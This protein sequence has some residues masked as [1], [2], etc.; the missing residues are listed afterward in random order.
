MRIALAGLVGISLAV[1]AS[2]AV[3]QWP[4]TPTSALAIG[5]GTGQ[6]AN[7]RLVAAA[8]GSCYVSWFDSRST[9]FQPMLQRLS[10]SGVEQWA[11]NGISFA[12]NTNTGLYEPYP[13]LAVDAAGNA[14][15][16]FT[17]TS[18][19]VINAHVTVNK[20]SPAGVKLWGET[21]ISVP[22]SSSSTPGAKLAVL[23]NGDVVV[24]CA[25]SSV[26][27]LTRFNSSGVQLGT[28]I[29]ISE[30][31]HSML[32]SD[33]CDGGNGSVIAL[34]QRNAGTSF[35]SLHSLYMQKFDTAGNAMWPV[36]PGATAVV[37]YG[38]TG[39]IAGG[40][41]PTL[42]PDGNGGAVCGWYELTGPAGSGAFSNALVQH[43]RSNGVFRF[44]ANG[45]PVSPRPNATS[46]A[47]MSVGCT[48]DYLP[49]TDEI[50]ATWVETLAAQQLANYAV[51]AQKI[52]VTDG[53]DGSEK[54]ASGG[55]VLRAVD[56][57]TQP[58]IITTRASQ[59]GCYSLWLT[60]LNAANGTIEAQR[61]DASGTKLWNSGDPLVFGPTPGYYG[62]RLGAACLA[63]G[64]LAVSFSQSPSLS[65][66]GS[67]LFVTRLKA[68]GTFGITPCNAADVAGFGGSQGPDGQVTVDDIVFYLSNFFSG[69]LAVADVA[70]FGGGATPDGQI[71]VDDLVYFLSQFF[72]PCN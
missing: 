14:Y 43:V 71:T 68:D 22:D 42:T 12:A 63:S 51:Y 37:L 32:M 53:I 24:G 2:S 59:G 6:Q 9:P 64:D 5:D 49:E 25:I 41:F 60:N 36:T 18:A 69:T 17:D 16:A 65:T 23:S 21:G 19:G 40:Y 27:K 58:A 39:G 11:H 38:T 66:S 10:A 15:I 26:L 31:G 57:F 72:S 44:Q 35:N 4:M 20:V 62:N 50:V 33:L 3:A 46:G 67:D 13:C 52:G 55:I 8:D 47:T 28:T 1:S 29:N 70:G 48:A 7:S 45:L 30:P 56:G 54:W 61:I 34:W